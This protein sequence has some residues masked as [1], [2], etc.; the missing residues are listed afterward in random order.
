MKIIL[1]SITLALF[2]SQ[3]V[4]AQNLVPNHSAE[5]TIAC[6][7][8]LGD[9][10]KAKY[11]S[12]PNRGTSDYFN[13]CFIDLNWTERPTVGVPLNGFGYQIHKSGKAYAGIHPY[14]TAGVPN[15]REYV[16]I[17]LAQP[18]EPEKIYFVRYYLSRANNFVIATSNFS[19]Y[20]SKE[21][22]GRTGFDADTLLYTPQ[23]NNPKGNFLNDSVN[24]MGLS[25]WYTAQGGE[26]FI[27]I[28]NFKD[29]ANIDT[30]YTDN[31]PDTL[32]P[33]LV[34]SYYFIDDVCVSED[35]SKCNITTHLSDSK[36]TEPFKISNL[37]NEI[38]VML[39]ESILIEKPTLDIYSLTGNLL[40]TQTIF[41]KE[42][43]IN[44]QDWNNGIYLIVL[45]TNNNI[46]TQRFIVQH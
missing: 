3:L 16:Q 45:K 37:S 38:K 6:P 18:L 33:V 25:Y 21:K 28:G 20:F 43:L 23:L 22:L 46:F 9:L 15:Y 5:D 2:A 24:W 1:I 39:N 30:L 34:S 41:D 40:K 29:D 42:I 44:T 27:I 35:S 26:K 31:R 19:V 10:E 32:D 11:W 4:E 13:E 14:F 12:K 17:E 8:G 36:T 7:E